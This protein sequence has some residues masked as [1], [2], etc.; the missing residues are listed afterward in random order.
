FVN[1]IK[2]GLDAKKA[3][4]AAV[5]AE[6]KQPENGNGNGNGSGSGAKVEVPPKKNGPEN[7]PVVAGRS[8]GQQMLQWPVKGPEGKENPY[9]EL[10]FKRGHD[11]GMVRAFLDKDKAEFAAALKDQDEDALKKLTG[12]R[13]GELA[14]LAAWAGLPEPERKRTYDADAFDLPK[15]L[16]G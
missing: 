9:R 13:H 6:P 4:L 1:V 15:D 14:A 8:A 11:G 5:S 3:T 16:E 12:E 10:K 7:P 2:P